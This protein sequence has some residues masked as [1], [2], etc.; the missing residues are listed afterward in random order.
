MQTKQVEEVDHYLFLLQD[1]VWRALQDAEPFSSLKKRF[2]QLF[3]QGY[4][5]GL[6]LPRAYLALIAH[7]LHLD[8]LSIEPHQLPNGTALLDVIGWCESREIP[9]P[10]ELAQLGVLWM[11]LGVRLKNEVL[12]RAGLK[13]AI[14]HVHLLDRE[15]RPH[16]S[17]WSRACSF[18]GSNLSV[19]NHVLFTIAYR[20]TG[21]AGFAK[22]SEI[23]QQQLQTPS[24]G[25][26]HLGFFFFLVFF[27]IL[28][29]R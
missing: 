3:K 28:T 21:E 16:L 7:L 26:P 25:G 6:Q 14:W 24:G 23:A 2:G 13:I 10:T 29:I 20:L 9:E 27:I 8:S 18:R 22:L 11:I 4:P 12:Q 1:L 5:E 19:W 15:G 17:L